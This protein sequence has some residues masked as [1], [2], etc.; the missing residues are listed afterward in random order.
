MNWGKNAPCIGETSLE[1]A[2]KIDDPGWLKIDNRA[3]IRDPGSVNKPHDEGGIFLREGRHRIE[4]GE[5][6]L[7]GGSYI[8]LYWR[9]PGRAAEIVPT[10]A[11]LPDR[12]GG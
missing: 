4:V 9:P 2:L 10:E 5:R 12:Y 8:H 6:N 11:L 3:V 7:A 1:H